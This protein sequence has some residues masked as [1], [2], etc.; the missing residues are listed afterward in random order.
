MTLFLRGQGEIT[1]VE[2][3]ISYGG[4]VD[5]KAVEQEDEVEDLCTTSE[6]DEE[7]DHKK[8]N[9]KRSGKQN[10]WLSVEVFPCLK[11]QH[12]CHKRFR[13]GRSFQR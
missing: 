4:M 8:R 13:R 6:E 7:I 5:K 9:R 12:A 1:A 3:W 10:S 11:Q 2:G